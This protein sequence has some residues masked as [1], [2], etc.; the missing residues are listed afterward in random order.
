MGY[1]GYVHALTELS[2]R[3]RD[4]QPAICLLC[5]RAE[6]CGTRQWALNLGPKSEP[7]ELGFLPACLSLLEERDKNGPF[8]G[9]RASLPQTRVLSARLPMVPPSGER[10]FTAS[11][12]ASL[13]LPRSWFNFFIRGLS[14]YWRNPVNFPPGA[15]PEESKVMCLWTYPYSMPAS[16]L[17][18][19]RNFLSARDWSRL[20][21]HDA[22]LKADLETELTKSH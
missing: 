2:E 21:G 8:W 19:P 6:W 20:L 7:W 22:V 15:R 10:S 18:L 11:T 3:R 17:H 1:A 16:V 4:G 12:E 13:A 9:V 5:F 14:V